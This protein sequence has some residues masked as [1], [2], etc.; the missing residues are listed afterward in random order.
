MTAALIEYFHAR[1][2]RR[3]WDGA[4]PPGVDRLSLDDAYAVQDAVVARRVEAG[5]VVAG[6]KVGCTS[7]AIRKKF[8]LTEPVAAHLFRHEIVPNGDTL[9]LAQFPNLAIEAE[10]ALRIARDIGADAVA[11]HTWIDGVA[12]VIE[13]HNFTF[14]W[15]PP[16]AAELVA[17]N[18]LQAGI[19]L[20]AWRDPSGIDLDLEGLGGFVDGAVRDS[21]IGAETLGG[22]LNALAWLRDHL[23]ARGQP[24]ARGQIVIPGSPAGLVPVETPSR[25]EAR[26]TRTGTAHAEVV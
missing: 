15:T 7:R 5:A 3:R 12:P 8:G 20:G 18:A 4:L 6:W 21:A 17:S 13:L 2:T 19:V 26:L 10:F 24:L 22:P 1:Q 25:I 9:S 23:A 11:P 16:S 14:A